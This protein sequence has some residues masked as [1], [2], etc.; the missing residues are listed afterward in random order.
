MVKE[1]VNKKH[2]HSFN[3]AYDTINALATSQGCYSRLRAEMVECSWEPLFELC[4]EKYFE[5]GV[6]FILFIEG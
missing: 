2:G 4:K 3:V 5:D 1:F 6:D